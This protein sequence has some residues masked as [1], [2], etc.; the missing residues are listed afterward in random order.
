MG[1]VVQ[2]YV[3]KLSR[4]GAGTYYM[5]GSNAHETYWNVPNAI[6]DLAAVRSL[7]PIAI[8]VSQSLGLDSGVRGQWQ[9]ILDNLVPYPTGNGA[10]LPH[11]PPIAQTRNGENVAAE[12][13]WPYN[14][15]G[16]GASDYQT[17]VNTWNQRPFPY[18]NV[19]ANDAVQAA[20]LGL[21]D[22]AYQGMR[23]M[24]Q[25]Y[26]NHPN[27]LTDNDNGVFE[28]LGVHLSVMNEALMQ[29]YND[30]IRVFPAVPGDSGFV[31]KFTLLAK[32]G[33]LVSSER[34]AGEI[35]YVGLKSLYGNQA[36]VVNP[37]G[38]QQVQVRRA[39][40]NA[41]VAS[42]A[43]GE[44]SFGTS[45]NTAYI[46][47]RAAKP[48]SG[49]SA[50]TLTGTANQDVKSLRN[51]A[52]TL[53]IGRTT[54]WHGQRHRADLRRRL[55]PHHQPGL[56]RLQRRHPP[57]DDQRPGGAVHVQRHRRR[58]LL[59]TQRRHGQRGRLHRRGLPGQRQ[60][61]RERAE[62]GT[63]GGL[64]QDRAAERLAHDQDR[65]PDDLGRDRR[66]PQHPVAG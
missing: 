8:Q 25:K 30:K 50:T 18:G 53:G 37:W 48:F 58:V 47:E 61:V 11:Q 13:I 15:T 29:S 51:T 46:V 52:S 27:G 32:D 28:Y 4:D 35:K 20:R 10:Y 34:E 23:T 64:P 16:I 22:Q 33:F 59:R 21:G 60:P 26:Q 6:T 2:L 65:E 1:D 12:L 3:A 66:R 57:H 56:R 36:R 19:W 7:F 54:R 39:S 45:A 49:Y 38:T 31:G 63:A 9:I 43:S 17:A 40:D 5:A 14:V 55:V 41:I 62:T 44:I 24:L 42:G